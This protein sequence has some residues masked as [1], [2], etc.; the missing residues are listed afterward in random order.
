MN[1]AVHSIVPVAHPHDNGVSELVAR[2][3]DTL[4]RLLPL[5]SLIVAY[6]GGKDSSCVANLVL[7]TAAALVRQGVAPQPI[8]VVHADTGVDNPAV[9]NYCAGQLEAMRAYGETNALPLEIRQTH[10]SLLQRYLVRII[11]GRALPT[12]SNSGN[13][14]CSEDLKI[15]PV[16]ACMNDIVRARR[17]A[18]LPAPVKVL[19]TRFTESASRGAR[20]RERGE[21]A[22]AVVDSKDGGRLLSLIADWTT[23]DVWE[24][25][26]SCGRGLAFD[27]YV[28]DFSGTLKLYRDA[29][30]ECVIVADARGKTASSACGARH[31][32]WMCCANGARDKSMEALLLQE[33]YAH[34]QGLNALRNYLLATQFDWSKR[35]YLGRKLHERT[36]YAAY[37]PYAYSAEMCDFLLRAVLT[38]DRREQARA[39]RLAEDIRAGRVSATPEMQALA[40]PQFQNLSREEVLAIDFIWSVDALH[41]PFHALKVWHEVMELGHEVDIPVIEPV[42][43]IPAPAARYGHVGEFVTAHGLDGL[44]DPISVLAGVEAPVNTGECFEISEEALWFVFEEE[45]SRLLAVHDREDASPSQ[46]FFYYTRMGFVS[47]AKGHL[48]KLEF[49]ARRGQ[50]WEASGLSGV[51]P[52]NLLARETLTEVEH[53]LLATIRF[54][55]T[56][57][58]M[59]L[60]HTPTEVQLAFC[61]A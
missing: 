32:C 55:A 12:F 9:A 5:E 60:P 4:Q 18:G 47:V 43:R 1:A 13:R 45:M 22:D 48:G 10:P 30:G 21:R 2:A 59:D 11:G 27:A 25:L 31:G 51:S 29:A 6:S 61:Y 41:C 37:R 56:P 40:A 8:Y 7:T 34:L 17:L 38:L 24:Y 46:A 15:A 42:A 39:S 14:A 16:R 49:M 3:V 23:D 57:V 53:A 19:G 54:G 26:M 28:P 52:D 50:Y 58:P 44:R 20:M 33:P 36:G 35:R